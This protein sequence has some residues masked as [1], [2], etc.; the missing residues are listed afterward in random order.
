MVEWWNS[1]PPMLKGTVLML[2]A[3]VSFS[4]LLLLIRVVGQ[5]LPVVLVV[6]KVVKGYKKFS[7][8]PKYMVYN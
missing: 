8:T 7:S 6:N 3:V 5:A 2:C 1:R 4:A